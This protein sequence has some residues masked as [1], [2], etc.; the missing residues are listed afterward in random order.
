MHPRLVVIVLLMHEDFVLF[1][2]GCC[3]LRELSAYVQRAG[4]DQ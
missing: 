4:G 1:Q 3:L 2:E